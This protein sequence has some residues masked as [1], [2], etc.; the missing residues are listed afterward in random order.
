LEEISLPSNDLSGPISGDIVNLAKLTYLELYRNK[1]SGKLPIDIGKL[2]KLKHILLDENSLTGSLPPSLVNCTNLT[3]LIL[4]TNFLEGNISTFNFSSLH[5]LTVIDL[6]DNKFS[7][8]LPVSLY[9]CK[10]L[11]AI[12]LARNQ[13]EGQIQ[14]DVLQLKFL[15]FLSLTSNRLTNITYA[16]K[17]LM[18]CKALGVV[19][20]GE[21][22]LHEAM[23]SDDNI[24]D[25]DGFENLRL[26]SLHSCQLS[27]Q[28][29]IWLSRLKKLEFLSLA[30]NRITGS[31]PNWLSTLPRLFH[32]DLS[33]TLIS[34]EF[35]KEFCGLQTLVSP[36]AL[37]D[38]NHWDLPIF[39]GYNSSTS[40]PAQFSFKPATSNYCCKL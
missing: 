1:L 22:F 27:G 26:F 38:N 21:N 39:I 13:L 40:G 6:G 8:N 16:I 5:Q 30:R 14:P 12:R 34:G 24:V 29:P 35:P 19:F 37:V 18:R 3:K 4:R 9:S 7:G 20:L 10:S 23:P 17:I 31:I 25:Y 36:K 15:S 33:E 28:L 2:S 32:L 11:T